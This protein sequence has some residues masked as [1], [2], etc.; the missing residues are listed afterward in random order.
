MILVQS[1]RPIV[2]SLPGTDGFSHSLVC[3]PVQS[4]FDVCRIAAE[5]YV[6]NVWQKWN[7]LHSSKCIQN[8][9]LENINM[10]SLVEREM[11]FLEY[12]I[13]YNSEVNPG[14]K[15]HWQFSVKVCK[16][17]CVISCLKISYI[18]CDFIG[19]GACH[20]WNSII[21]SI[22]L[23]SKAGRFNTHGTQH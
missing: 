10:A 7:K 6:R 19:T 14:G 4:K 18:V 13:V 16:Q 9:L 17:H 15:M 11:K 22:Q 8:C 21:Q 12:T 23:H 1:E 3:Q 2:R 20:L 5:P